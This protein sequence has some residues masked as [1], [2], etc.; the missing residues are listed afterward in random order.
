MRAQTRLTVVVL[1]FNTDSRLKRGINAVRDGC[2]HT[3]YSWWWWWWWWLWGGTIG[4]LTLRQTHGFPRETA[5]LC[6]RERPILIRYRVF[7]G[8]SIAL[9]P[10]S[11]LFMYNNNIMNED[12]SAALCNA[13][14]AAAIMQK[15]GDPAAMATQY[16]FIPARF[17]FGYHRAFF[18]LDLRVSGNLWSYEIILF[19]ECNC[20]TV[21]NRNA[22]RAVS[23]PAPGAP[24]RSFSGQNETLRS[25]SIFLN[26]NFWKTTNT[27]KTR[28]FFFR[29][30]TMFIVEFNFMFFNSRVIFLS[31]CMMWHVVL[32]KTCSWICSPVMFGSKKPC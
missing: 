30:P 7:A 13:R 20:K 19:S 5:S 1:G 4:I 25:K 17:S 11:D 24:K 23:G 9:N 3:P 14:S 26:Y 15:R 16:H 22:A 18:A 31:S 10:I 6:P 28:I 2:Q 8:R 12:H 27:I 32:F 21:V 29:W